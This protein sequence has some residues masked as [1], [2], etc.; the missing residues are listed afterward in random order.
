LAAVIKNSVVVELPDQDHI[1][2]IVAP[3]L[4]AGELR[5]F[6]AR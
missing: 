6:F 2:H 4:L 1:A 3:R 5:R